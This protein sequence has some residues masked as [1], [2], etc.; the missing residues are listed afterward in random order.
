[1]PQFFQEL[2][3]YLYKNGTDQSPDK[4]KIGWLTDEH[5]NAWMEFLI[6]YRS[7]DANW[8]VA[9]SATAAWLVSH[10]GRVPV[11]SFDSEIRGT[12]NGS[13]PP[14][15]SWDNIQWVLMPLHICGNHWV[16]AI[17]NL[18]DSTFYVLDSMEIPAHRN[19]LLMFLS[20]WTDVLNQCLMELG[21][22]ERTGRQPYKFDLNY[23]KY[24]YAIPQQT[25]GSD[26]GVITCWL[27][28]QFVV[29]SLPPTFD[30]NDV[31]SFRVTM[32]RLFYE[33]R[34]EITSNCGY[35]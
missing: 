1:M 10:S 15:P 22:F 14:Y 21:H 5:M 19:D 11:L 26:C 35:D 30:S 17:I 18:H 31:D 25:N 4:L 20:E 32:G 16:T 12:L 24:G 6:R 33:C 27:I 2:L 13:T 8:T 9:K 23:N 3:P 7:P 29:G 34:C 28:T